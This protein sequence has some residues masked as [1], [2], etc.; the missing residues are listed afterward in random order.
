MSESKEGP[1]LTEPVI[2]KWKITDL[3]KAGSNVRTE[4][5]DETMDVLQQSIRALGLLQLPLAT[6]EGEV[7]SGWGRVEALTHEGYTEMYVIEVDRFDET[8]Q[9][10]ASLSENYAR[11]DLFDDEVRFALKRLVQKGLK[12]K[13]IAQ[14]TGMNES[15]VYN[16]LEFYKLPELAQ[17]LAK[18]DPKPGIY[19]VSKISQIVKG[20][21]EEQ[22]EVVAK[23]LVE[24]AKEMPRGQRKKGEYGYTR[25]VPTLEEIADM[26]TVHEEQTPSMLER[27]LEQARAKT[28]YMTITVSIPED[29]YVPWFRSAKGTKQTIN[30]KII[31][32]MRDGLSDDMASD[33][34]S[35]N[36]IK[37]GRCPGPQEDEEDE[38]S[39]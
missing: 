3:K 37:R 14:K 33:M 19:T 15:T 13:D 29:T 31:E 36:W 32:W 7:F 2:T 39:S 5:P 18:E 27:I 38:N 22:Q 21:P 16:L 23:T 17:E 20:Q 34:P 26:A 8:D 24:I 30:E 28:E 10:I 4:Y 25:P 35:N 1:K 12:P 6:P 9:I 11:T